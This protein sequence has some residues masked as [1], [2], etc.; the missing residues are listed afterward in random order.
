MF[1]KGKE[2]NVDEFFRERIEKNECVICHSTK[3]LGKRFILRNRKT[4]P[5]KHMISH[6]FI[7]AVCKK[8]YYHF[9]E[10]QNKCDEYYTDLLGVSFVDHIKKLYDEGKKKEFVDEIN[11]Y[12]NTFVTMDFD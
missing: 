7:V 11:K 12:I 5:V 2:F 6:F 3:F 4:I 1:T 9:S 10:K 8:C